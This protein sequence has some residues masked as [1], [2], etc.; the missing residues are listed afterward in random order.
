MERDVVLDMGDDALRCADSWL[1]EAETCYG[2]AGH[3]GIVELIRA[4]RLSLD[5]LPTLTACPA[6]RLAHV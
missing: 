5:S 4:A 3:G 2:N 6:S 1:R